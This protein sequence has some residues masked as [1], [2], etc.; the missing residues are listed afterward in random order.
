M[1]VNDGRMGVS[2]LA[3]SRAVLDTLKVRATLRR[4]GAGE[5]S[6]SAAST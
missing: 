1:A 4:L 2:S 6:S 3:N 5:G